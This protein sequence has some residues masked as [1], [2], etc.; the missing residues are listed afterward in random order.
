MSEL[1]EHLDVSSVPDDPRSIH[2]LFAVLFNDIDRRA[3]IHQ[4]IKPEILE[5]LAQAWLYFAEQQEGVDVIVEQHRHGVST[6]IDDPEDDRPASSIGRRG[7]GPS[8]FDE[9]L[10]NN[11]DFDVTI[12]QFERDMRRLD[13]LR[14]MAA[15][16]GMNTAESNE[17]KELRERYSLSHVDWWQ[18]RYLSESEGETDSTTVSRSGKASA[19]R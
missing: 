13:D 12:G 9:R 3:E 19:S 14:R 17:A 8:I 10:M 15:H 2:T 6:D 7:T 1:R 18:R 16:P 11:A 5:G 4:S